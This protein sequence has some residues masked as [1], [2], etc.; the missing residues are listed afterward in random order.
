M[1]EI[2]VQD[3]C[4]VTFDRAFRGYRT[5]HVD[6][7]LSALAF[8][9][10]AGAPLGD[11]QHMVRTRHFPLAIGG[12]DCAHVDA[13]IESAASTWRV[14]EEAAELRDEARTLR[15]HLLETIEALTAA[16]DRATEQLTGVP[17][18]RG[19]AREQR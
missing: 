9:R 15:A 5:Q 13:L 14:Y 6:A 12:Y 7:F 1:A 2:V 18:I 8:A 17:E 16:L 4:E 3:A 19:G 11:L 10:R